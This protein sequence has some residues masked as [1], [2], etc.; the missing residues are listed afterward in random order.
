V[1]FDHGLNSAV[2][3]LREALNDSAEGPKYIETLARRGYR[4]IATVDRPTQPVVA[5]D[6]EY[7]SKQRIVRRLI[8]VF[9]SAVLLACTIWYFISGRVESSL[10]PPRVIP[11]T[12]LP[13]R[14]EGPAFSPDGNYVAFARYSDSPEASGIYIAEVGSSRLLQ[15]TKKEQDSFCC[16]V[17]SPDGR[18][19]AF[20]RFP[21][22]EHGI[23]HGIYMVSAIGG[24]ERKLFSG[25]PAHPPLDWSPDGRSIAFTAKS[26]PNTMCLHIT[27]GGNR[28]TGH[29]YLAKNRTFLLCVDTKAQAIA[30]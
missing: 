13:D 17:W 2:A 8:L 4:F 28:G 15:L 29:F 27:P 6:L 24:A 21:K 12:S 3:R 11:L 1:D 9:A 20:S 7:G 25:A 22:E 23:Y 14:A 18:Y 30:A 10:R 19:I 16:P 26:N 5:R